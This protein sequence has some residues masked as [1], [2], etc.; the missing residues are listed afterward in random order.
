MVDWTTVAVSVLGSI[1]SSG[2]AS[3]FLIG[4]RIKKEQRYERKT[5]KENWYHQVDS[6][7]LRIWRTSLEI[8]YEVPIDTNTGMPKDTDEGR[9]QLYEFQSL[10]QRLLE[11]HTEAPPEIDRS[12][13]K[14]IET[15]GYWY[16]NME[17]NEVATTT[18]LREYIQPEIESVMEEIANKS[19]RY[20]QPSYY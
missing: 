19:E 10:L 2:L 8:P 20:N 1:G 12:M 18:D 4:R 17:F 14:K 6:I 5:Q 15:I 7:C 3:W 11:I 9:E 13:L 16:D